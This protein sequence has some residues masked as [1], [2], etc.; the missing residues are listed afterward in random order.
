LSIFLNLFHVLLEVWGRYNAFP[1]FFDINDFS[2]TKNHIIKFESVE[3]WRKLD[4]DENEFI[5]DEKRAFY[6]AEMMLRAQ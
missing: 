3:K 5:S 6:R 4:Q 2:I 1:G